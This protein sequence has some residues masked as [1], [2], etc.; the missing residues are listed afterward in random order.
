MKEL[1]CT[2]SEPSSSGW[3]V[4]HSSSITSS[5]FIC[6]ASQVQWQQP[7]SKGL[8]T[9]TTSSS[10]HQTNRSSSTFTVMPDVSWRRE[11]STSAAGCL[12]HPQLVGWLKTLFIGMKPPSRRSWVTCTTPSKT[13]CHSPTSTSRSYHKASQRDNFWATSAKSS[14]LCPWFYLWPSEDGSSWSRCGRRAQDGTKKYHP[15]YYR[16]WGLLR[17]DLTSLCE[18]KFPRKT[19]DTELRQP[20][21][22]HLFCDG[23]KT[24]YGFACYLKQ[25]GSVPQLVFAKGKLA[26]DN[27]SI[28][29]LE[30]LSVFL[31][32]KCIPLILD[33]INVSV[34]HIR[35]WSDAQVVLEWLTSGCKSKSKFTS[36][37][38]EDIE[39]MKLKMHNQ[40]SCEISHHYVPTSSN[41][42]DMLTRGLTAKEF[43]KKVLLW[44]HGPDWLSGNSEQWPTSPL[45][46]LSEEAKRAV[47]L[48]HQQ[49]RIEPS[50]SRSATQP[51]LNI[52]DFS[53]LQR[54][55]GVAARVFQFINKLK[56]RKADAKEQ[57]KMYWLKMMQEES[58]D[59]E[60]SFLKARD[61]KKTTNSSEVPKLLSD[62][63][64]FLDNTGM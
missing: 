20:T 56:R 40:L 46:C 34:D 49:V 63:N 29:Q 19:G 7:H 39:S 43:S 6:R 48:Q 55:N 59:A 57:A 38:L 32:L 2:V 60:I 47:E 17:N 50:E 53:S 27:K 1:K 64:G 21:E 14:T 28:P 58:F 33:S 52:N 24:C 15:T 26:P 61:Q 16:E 23:S 30:L 11:A 31:A 10:Q 44:L 22:L 41:V 35:I 5:N 37:R 4:L 18:L 54:L 13:K 42:A 3:T 51:I 62:L 8:C 36:N 45:Y 9:Q 12:T 25:E